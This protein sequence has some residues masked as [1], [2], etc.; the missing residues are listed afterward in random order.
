MVSTNLIGASKAFKSVLEEI[1]MVGPLECSVLIQG[2]RQEP[3]RRLLRAQF[4][5]MDRAAISPS[6]P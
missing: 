5:M 1:C 3:V 4:T 6:L 2:A